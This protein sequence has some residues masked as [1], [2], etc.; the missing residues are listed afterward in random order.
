MLLSRI[1]PN[2][3]KPLTGDLR[4]TACEACSKV[5]SSWCAEI[6]HEE[7][8]QIFVCS[9]CMLYDTEWGKKAHE[10]IEVVILENEK[11]GRTFQKDDSR[12]LTSA[13]EADN[14]LGSIVL[15]LRLEGAQR[16]ADRIKPQ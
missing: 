11:R 1:H 16:T 7:E 8:N 15:A 2:M 5:Q 13:M 3:I 12:H 4:G 6:P 10:R 9:L 14:V